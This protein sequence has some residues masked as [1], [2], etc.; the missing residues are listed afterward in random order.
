MDN[1]A[2]RLPLTIK[3]VLFDLDFTLWRVAPPFLGSTN[4][5]DLLTAKE[6][7]SLVRKKQVV[8]LGALAAGSAGLS[9]AGVAGCASWALAA[10]TEASEKIRVPAIVRNFIEFLLSYMAVD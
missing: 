6:L 10:H 9:A 8:Q 3:A 4:P 7:Q 5:H 2:G 1:G